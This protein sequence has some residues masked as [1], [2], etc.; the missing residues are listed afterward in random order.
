MARLLLLADAVACSAQGNQAKAVAVAPAKPAVS[1][2]ERKRRKGLTTDIV[3]PLADGAAYTA[4]DIVEKLGL[5]PK[6]TRSRR[7]AV[8]CSG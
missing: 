1:G 2:T 7:S 4:G 5:Q 3:G 8:R 6:K